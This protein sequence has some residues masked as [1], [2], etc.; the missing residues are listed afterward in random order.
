MSNKMSTRDKV[1]LAL[2]PSTYLLSKG[3]E[4]AVEKIQRMSDSSIQELNTEFG[5]SPSR[6]FS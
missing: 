6:T 4:I 1:W 2:S 3:A 5:I